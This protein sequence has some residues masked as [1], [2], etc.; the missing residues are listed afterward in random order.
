MSSSSMPEL[1]MCLS[2]VIQL[3]WSLHPSLE[4][5]SVEGCQ[6]LFYRQRPTIDH[7]G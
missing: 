1:V 3:G 7:Q 6:L 4:V 2:V 5:N